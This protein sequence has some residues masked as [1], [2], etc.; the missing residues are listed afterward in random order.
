MSEHP[1]RD[2]AE[3]LRWLDHKKNVDKVFYVLCGLCAAVVLADLG[4]DKHGHFAF[5]NIIGFNAAFGFIAY[6][7]LILISKQLRKWLMR[8]ESYYD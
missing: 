4:Y 6:V 5:E 7:G 8:D 1:P 2:S 3:P